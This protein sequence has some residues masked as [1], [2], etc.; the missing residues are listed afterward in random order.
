MAGAMAARSRERR[1]FEPMWDASHRARRWRHLQLGRLFRKLD[2][3]HGDR[4]FAATTLGAWEAGR[5]RTADA[6]EASG[7]VTAREPR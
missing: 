4:L 1:P 3:R 5:L 2:Q 6:R 7:I